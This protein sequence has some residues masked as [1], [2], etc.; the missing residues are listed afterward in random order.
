MLPG[1]RILFAAV[2][3]TLSVV[4]FGLGAAAMLRAAHENA[5]AELTARSAPD[6]VFEV[7]ANQPT[8]SLLRVEEPHTAGVRAIETATHPAPAAPAAP[9]AGD[10][11]PVAESK[12]AL[13]PRTD[14]LSASGPPPAADVVVAAL[15]SPNNETS[16]IVPPTAVQ[17]APPVAAI[18]SSPVAAA[19]EP[20]PNLSVEPSPVPPVPA[21]PQ[22]RYAALD[23]PDG[24]SAVDLEVHETM[25]SPIAGTVPVPLGRTNALAKAEQQRRAAQERAAQQR[26]RTAA[27]RRARTADVAAPVVQ[28][29]DPFGTPFSAPATTSR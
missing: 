20:G 28:S 15:P 11:A 24:V 25:L 5:V 18:E 17:I 14:A 12:A 7:V 27:T 9:S 22:K 26:R 3:L 8:L 10:V 2:V 4:V 23:P 1:L 29:A 19:S 13:P 6:P 16:E 21:A